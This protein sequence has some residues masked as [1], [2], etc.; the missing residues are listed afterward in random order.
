ML[1]SGLTSWLQYVVARI[2]S[3]HVQLDFWRHL[4]L[5][6]IT[7]TNISLNILF[8]PI[9]L[10]PFLL[11]DLCW[12]CLGVLRYYDQAIW[13]FSYLFSIFIENRFFSHTIKPDHSF[14]PSMILSFSSAPLFLRST[15]TPF[16]FRKKEGLQ[17]RTAKQDKTR[18]KKSLGKSPH[19]EAGVNPIG[20][21]ES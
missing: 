6:S 11:G 13:Y 2:L 8:W 14:P 21:K 5:E 20:E 10:I 17:E 4:C 3:S 19:I 12:L 16:P 15:P 9:A 7:P 18:Y 1:P